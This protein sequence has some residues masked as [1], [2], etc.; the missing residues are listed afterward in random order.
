MFPYSAYHTMSSHSAVTLLCSLSLAGLSPVLL[1]LDTAAYFNHTDSTYLRG[2]LQNEILRNVLSVMLK[3]LTLIAVLHTK[4][5]HVIGCNYLNYVN[6]K[7]LT[8]SA[9]QNAHE[10]FFGIKP[11]LVKH[12]GSVVKIKRTKRTSTKPEK[13]QF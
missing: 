11:P 9:L 8:K 10:A 12:V 1:W 2:S 6:I 4:L 7:Q 5:Q 3:L 13:S